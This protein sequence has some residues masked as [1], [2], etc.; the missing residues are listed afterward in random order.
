MNVAQPGKG[1][2]VGNFGWTPKSCVMP[3]RSWHRYRTRDRR[4]SARHDCL[5]A[6]TPRRH[7]NALR[8][9]DRFD[10]IGDATRGAL[11]VACAQART[12]EALRRLEPI[13]KGAPATWRA[14]IRVAH[15]PLPDKAQTALSG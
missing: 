12:R 8:P 14:G 6:G 13:V 4:G 11:L 5:P 9:S 10:P 3:K 2:S 15:V 1:R 7:P